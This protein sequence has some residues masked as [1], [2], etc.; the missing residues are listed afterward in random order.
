MLNVGVFGN[1]LLID[2]F[3]RY[4][5]LLFQLY[6][7]QE[8]NENCKFSKKASQSCG[9]KAFASVSFTWTMANKV[10]FATVTQTVN[11]IKRILFLPNLN[12]QPV[13][14]FTNS[15]LLS[16]ITSPLIELK[17]VRK[18]CVCLSMGFQGPLYI[19]HTICFVVY[20]HCMLPFGR[21]P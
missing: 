7:I 18:S 5:F 1:Q 19:F 10:L 8:D 13:I 11:W 14:I 2:V 16:H 3:S 17:K 20:L 4:Q 21:Y 6:K 9:R 12:Q 15:I